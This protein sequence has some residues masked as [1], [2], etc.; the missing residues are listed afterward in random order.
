LDTAFSKEIQLM[1]YLL[2]T[3]IAIGFTFS[4]QAQDRL[5]SQTYSAPLTLNPA[6]TGAFDGKFRVSGI[7]RNQWNGI[8]EQPFQ[9]YSTAL[10]F[11]FGVGKG[12][13]KKDLAGAGI[14]FYTDKVG[15]LDFSTTKIAV[16]GAFHKALD[17]RSQ[18]YLSAGFQMGIVQRNINYS[19]VTFQDQFNGLTGFNDPTAED[20]PE[21]NFAFG[22]AS[23]GLNY[24]YTPAART[25]LFVGVGVHHFLTP[26]VSFYDRN[27]ALGIYDEDPLDIKYTLQVSGSLPL[28][29]NLSILPR[30]IGAY[31][32]SHLKVDAGT[33]FRIGLGELQKFALHIGGYARVVANET[34][35]AG[36]AAVTPS[37]FSVPTA[38]VLLGIEY[39]NI[40][41]GFSY[42]LNLKD[43]ALG[44][45]AFEISVAYLGEYEDDLLL[46]PKF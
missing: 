15:E 22:D 10:D 9:T 26:S 43:V 29:Q 40:L 37:A 4:A 33:N 19:S 32:G 20:L 31:Q 14:L 16:S 38:V 27:D 6:L 24:A 23:V 28:G 1:R 5:F 41:F 45:N 44:Q 30:F 2:L 13:K 39:S 34:E 35:I 25:S 12:Y 3:I 42:D 17:Q 36:S 11:K 8:L 18:Q 46:C 21:N 7:Y